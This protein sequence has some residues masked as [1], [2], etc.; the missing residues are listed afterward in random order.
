MLPVALEGRSRDKECHRGVG[1]GQE[2][3]KQQLKTVIQSCPVKKWVALAL[4]KP[5]CLG[6][7]Q[8]GLVVLEEMP[9]H[10]RRG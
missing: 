2:L 7:F 6:E 8:L 5:W 1:F 10:G 9:M 4:V 3:K